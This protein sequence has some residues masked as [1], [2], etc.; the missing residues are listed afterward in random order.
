MQFLNKYKY[1][2]YNWY[3][4]NI[5]NKFILNNNKLLLFWKDFKFSYVPILLYK[6][7]D[8]YDSRANVVKSP[9]LAAIGVATLSGFMFSLL[10]STITATM[11]N[12]IEIQF[13]L[14]L[15]TNC[16]Q[17]INMSIRNCMK[18][19]WPSIK[20]AEEAVN[21]LEAHKRKAWFESKC[22][23]GTQPIAT[24]A[25]DAKKPTTIAWH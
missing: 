18:Y 2:H 10:E 9:K 3:I 20:L 13:N 19:N 8:K 12:P 15:W 11:I 21:M 23:S 17:Y 7:E 5:L 25:K 22:P 4:E 6:Y 24:A 14:L 1:N 16:M